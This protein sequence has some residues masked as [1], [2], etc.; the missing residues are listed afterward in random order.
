MNSQG[1]RQARRSR[2]RKPDLAE[3]LS[4]QHEQFTAWSYW[5]TCTLIAMLLPL[6]WR[7]G[8]SAPAP[9]FNF[10]STVVFLSTVKVIACGLPPCSVNCR[11]R[12]EFFAVAM[13]M[14]KEDVS[15]SVIFPDTV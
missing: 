4:Q 10:P 5:T 9:T 3:G 12:L 8:T 11:P 6:S 7:Y 13:A 15:T 14:E 2:R 1:P